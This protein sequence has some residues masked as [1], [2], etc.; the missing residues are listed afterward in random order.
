METIVHNPLTTNWTRSV[1][2]GLPMQDLCCLTSQ[3]LMCL[4]KQDFGHVPG[5]PKEDLPLVGKGGPILASACLLVSPGQMQW[6]DGG[7]AGL[8]AWHD[9]QDVRPYRP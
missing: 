8:V 7:L 9:D 1:A 5:L 6:K 2:N 4:P 3:V